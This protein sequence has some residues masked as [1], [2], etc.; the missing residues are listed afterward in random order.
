[1]CPLDTG[2]SY[3]RERTF[4]WGSASMRSSCGAFFSV[5][6][7]GGRAY[8]GWC[9]SWA[10]SLG[11]YRRASWASQGKK[12]S[13][14]HPSMAS[15]S[16]PVSWPSWVP[17]LTSFSDEQQCGSVRWINL[18]LPNLHVGHD[19]CAGTETQTK[20]N[21]YHHSGVFL[22]Q[23]DHVLGRTVKGLWK[24]GLEDSFGVK[25]FVGCCVGTSK[26]ML[27]TVQK[28]ESWLVKFQRED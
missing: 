20:T 19:F 1:V 25:S 14:K 9:H 23:P 11:F 24:F 2:W 15:A 5:G 10:G 8:Y 17:V 27:R 4:R 7:Q 28:I 3:H 21:W 26:I 22:W 18:F 6:D 13:K 12:A 16:A